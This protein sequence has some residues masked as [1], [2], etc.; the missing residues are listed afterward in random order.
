MEQLVPTLEQA[1]ASTIL[2]LITAGYVWLLARV[3][4]H[5]FFAAKLKY[6]R[7]LLLELE[8]KGKHG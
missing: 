8:G 6:Q 2:V 7:A 3:V 5:A 1:A 4:S